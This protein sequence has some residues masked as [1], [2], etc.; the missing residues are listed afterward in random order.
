MIALILAASAMNSGASA[1]LISARAMIF[2]SLCASAGVSSTVPA[3]AG[4]AAR[5]AA[6]AAILMSMLPPSHRTKCR[7]PR[8]GKSCAMCC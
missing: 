3:N 5:I 2:S 1:P 7:L 8:C 4:D 6:T